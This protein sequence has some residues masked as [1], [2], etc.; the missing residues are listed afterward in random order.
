LEFPH[1]HQVLKG[2]QNFEEVV[3]FCSLLPT[4]YPPAK[5]AEAP[6]SHF[7]FCL[8]FLR[9]TGYAPQVPSFQLSL[10]IDETHAEFLSESLYEQGCLGEEWR[11][12]Q[13]MAMP[14]V[15]APPP[16]KIYIVS[17]F[18]TLKAAQAALEAAQSQWN[19][20]LIELVETEDKAWDMA[21]RERVSSTETQHLW[22]GPP[23]LKPSAGKQALYI[24][25]KMAFGTGE[26]PSTRLCLEEI[27][28]F[29]T[30]F[31]GCSLLDVGTGTGILGMAAC[32]LGADHALGIDNDFSV[33]PYVRENLMLN[34]ISNMQI[35]NAQ[36]HHIEG[37][38]DIV[39]ANIFANALEELAEALCKKTRKY[40]VLSGI[41]RPQS[42]QL[43]MR[44]SQL[45]MRLSAKRAFEEWVCLG[46]KTQ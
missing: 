22:V 42:A 39:V 43:E 27:E 33:F 40:L 31:P 21:W 25:P 32:K 1:G 17:F 28:A 36:L 16:G 30:H 19:V 12:T 34:E 15:S 6:W 46:F 11:E 4:K 35:S 3:E 45:G 5:P 9:Q 18:E 29:C 13:L 44:F 38:F 41:L 7:T 14:G 23:W 8:S 10:E 24:E 2:L 26:H 20:R 37:Q